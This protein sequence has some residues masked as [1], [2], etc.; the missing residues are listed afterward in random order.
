M[1][2]S[3]DISRREILW[4]VFGFLP[5]AG[6]MAQESAGEATFSS[7]VS[8]VNVLATV[9]DHSGKV[10][11]ALT[12]DDFVVEE[13]GRP[14]VIQYFSRQSAL[15]LTLG[16]L[17]DTSFSELRNID[18]E[19]KASHRFFDHVMRADQD[20]AFVLNFDTRVVLRRN[21]TS[22]LA[23]LR[24]ALDQV[25]REQD[26]GPGGPAIG[27]LL[28]DAV[29]GS[30]AQILGIQPGRKAIILFS[31]GEDLGSKTL[32][33]GAIEAA[34]RAE[35]LVYSIRF[36]DEGTLFPAAGGPP[37]GLGGRAGRGF[38]GPGPVPGGAKRPDGKR[39]LEEISQKTGGGYFEAGKAS[40]LDKIY[41]RIDD[42]L[43]SEYNLGYTSDHPRA[44]F[45]TLNVTT[46]RKSLKVQAR[47]GY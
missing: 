46:K 16:L 43:R 24:S 39:V 20:K 23:E 32:L 13:D 34:Q 30:A 2:R 21:L 18:A 10:V 31:D 1:L 25:R 33:A 5:A 9:R 26:G 17:M 42:E 15:P 8:V 28:Y 27:T 35:A 37:M 19:R 38:P 3:R 41:D 45:H 47:Q 12:K 40:T 4:S 7:S 11:N 36:S 29:A 44:G 14:Q 22:S 6:L